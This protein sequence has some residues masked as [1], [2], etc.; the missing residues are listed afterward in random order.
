[1]WVSG[2]RRHEKG[3]WRSRLLLLRFSLSFTR[4]SILLIPMM[5]TKGSLLQV[6]LG[7]PCASPLW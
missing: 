5:E 6:R 3:R 1:M 4:P 2:G 7:L